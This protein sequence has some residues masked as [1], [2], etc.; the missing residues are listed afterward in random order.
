MQELKKVY[1]NVSDLVDSRAA[2]EPVEILPTKD[3]LRHS[4]LQ[5]G[6]AFPKR[7]AI[8]DSSLKVFLRNLKSKESASS[9]DG[10]PPSEE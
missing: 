1:V 6:K 8:E 4:I 9:K 10:S 7:Q 2:R 5:E 3:A